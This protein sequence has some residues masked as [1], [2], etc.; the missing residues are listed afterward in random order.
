MATFQI[1]VTSHEPIAPKGNFGHKEQDDDPHRPTGPLTPERCQSCQKHKFRPVN[2]RVVSLWCF[3]T[4]WQSQKWQTATSLL[5]ISA[6]VYT[7]ITWWPVSVCV[8]VYVSV[9]VR[10]CACTS[11]SHRLPINVCAICCDRHSSPSVSPHL[12]APIVSPVCLVLSLASSTPRPQTLEWF[13]LSNSLP[14][15][16]SHTLLC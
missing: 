8:C 13:H 14:L 6:S 4:D 12:S 10:V 7:A 3:L 15:S 11:H 16:L 2:S 9:Q 1:F 5:C